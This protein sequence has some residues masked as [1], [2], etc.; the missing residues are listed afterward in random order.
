MT[1]EDYNTVALLTV[2]ELCLDCQAFVH[3]Q[4]PRKPRLACPVKYEVYLTG[5]GGDESAQLKDNK[6]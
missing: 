6:I 2:R 1:G 4:V 3:R 5:V